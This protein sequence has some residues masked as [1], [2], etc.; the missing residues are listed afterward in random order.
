[1]SE[2]E[3]AAS[4]QELERA[5]QSLTAEF[6]RLYSVAA[7]EVCPGLTPGAYRV[8]VV[9]AKESTTASALAERLSC[10]KAQISR[11]V[12]DLQRFDLVNAIPDPDDRRVKRLEATPLAIER[13]NR[14][15]LPYKKLIQ[16]SVQNWPTSQVD[17]L[18]ALLRELAAGFGASFAESRATN[19]T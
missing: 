7:D 5:F 6:Q 13:L 18:S 2:T 9:I 14:S 8:L 4:V 15:N 3:H 16:T 12:G 1:M 19:R 10:D 17:S 11:H